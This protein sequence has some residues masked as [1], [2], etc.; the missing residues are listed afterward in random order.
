MKR[1]VQYGEW[2]SCYIDGELDADER[3]ELMRHLRDCPSCMD[4][5]CAYEA[6]SAGLSDMEEE[7]PASLVTGVMD[8]IALWSAVP[9]RGR[10]KPSHLRRFAAVAAVFAVVGVIGAYGVWGDLEIFGNLTSPAPAP[11]VAMDASLDQAG[12]EPAYM[13]EAPVAVPADAAG[14]AEPSRDGQEHVFYMENESEALPPDVIVRGPEARGPED[15][16]EPLNYW[17]QSETDTTFFDQYFTAL[18]Y[19]MWTDLERAFQLAGYEY[20][21]DD[22]I[23][24]VQDPYNYGSYLYGHVMEHPTRQGELK[25][26]VL[27]YHFRAGDGSR[28]MELRV[29]GGE[30]VFS[31]AV[32]RDNEGWTRVEN[33]ETL[34]DIILLRR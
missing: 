3:A 2:I 15:S 13:G 18:S 22:D 33:W 32:L 9:E 11:G 28:M 26:L 5:L 6:I 19:W 29:E 10:R 27:G 8:E 16:I 14:G 25:V 4:L 12:A 24:T 1:C 21:L 7:P 31:Y 20:F 30:L 23:F 17:D 34:R